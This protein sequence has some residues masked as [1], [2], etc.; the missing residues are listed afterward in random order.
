M[1]VSSPWPVRTFVSGGSVSRRSRI[2]SMIVGKWE[3]ERP[4]APGPPLKRV[5]PVKTTPSP[6]SYRQT[7]P[8][9]WPGVCRTVRSAPA[10]SITWPSTRRSSGSRS[11]WVI[12][13]NGRSSRCSQI[14]A[15][16]RS[17]R[18]GA[19][20]TWSLWAWVHTIAVSRRSPTASAM[21]WASWAASMT[22]A[23]WSSPTIQTLLSTSQVPPSRVNCPEVTRRSIRAA[24]T[25]PPP[26]AARRR[27]ASARTP[28]PPRPVGWSR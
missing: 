2:E 4:V 5:S 10:A 25:A 3:Y 24:I 21:A 1:V 6:G 14:V 19:A 7:A 15:P 23:S 8:G 22:T 9:A 20:L 16:V 12:F 13:H 17:A 11:G 18:A 27:G 28:S 26:S